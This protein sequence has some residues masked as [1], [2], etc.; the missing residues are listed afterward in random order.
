MTLLTDTIG[1]THLEVA[2]NDP[3]HKWGA[4]T[5]HPLY[6]IWRGVLLRCASLHPAHF[7]KYRGRG[8]R[9]CDRWLSF[10]N[11]VADMGERPSGMS[12]ERKDN[13]GNYEPSNCCWADKRT[14][15]RNRRC[16]RPLTLDG[17]TQLLSDWAIE[18][19]MNVNTL[20]MRIDTYKWPLSKALTT[21][22]KEKR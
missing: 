9:V 8:I 10:E 15:A 22:V 18:L 20:S 17:R 12:I 21:P 7:S 1:T 19:G 14:Q 5:K 4:K 2:M 6:W 11:F 16:A 13:N 3:L